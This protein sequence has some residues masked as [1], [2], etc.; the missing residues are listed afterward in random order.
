MLLIFFALLALAAGWRY[1]RTRKLAWALLCGA[2]VGLM[3]AT[4]E[5]FII[6]LVCAGL[7]LCLNQVWN[8]LLDASGVPAKAQPIRAWHVAAAVGVWLAVAFLFFSSFF[9]NASGPLDSLRT[10]HRWFGRAGGDSPHV[11]PWNFFLERL[12][13][14]H[15]SKGPLWSEAFILVLAIVGY[16]PPHFFAKVWVKSIPVWCVFSPSTPS[17][18]WPR[19]V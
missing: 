2:G 1:W 4:K 5:T 17:A 14:Y 13:Y 7:A 12:L 18:F 8:R 11:Y 3:H 9:T 6:S 16:R 10:Y 19:T 15:V